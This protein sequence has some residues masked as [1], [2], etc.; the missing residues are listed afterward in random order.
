MCSSS[1]QISNTF[2]PTWEEMMM[3][4]A[5]D[6]QYPLVE[7][8]VHCEQPD[9][10]PTIESEYNC[11]CRL[12]FH[13]LSFLSRPPLLPLC[14]LLYS[15][16]PS[17]IFI[18]TLQLAAPSVLAKCCRHIDRTRGDIPAVATSNTIH[19]CIQKAYT[20]PQCDNAK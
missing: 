6:S 8:L 15:H 2:L 11:A 14:S 1:C 9:D 20:I 5:L 16:R 18:S 7:L 17:L 12:Q 19:Q 10:L 3:I 13:L 4:V